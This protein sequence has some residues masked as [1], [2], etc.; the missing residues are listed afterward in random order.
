MKN[1]HISILYLIFIALVLVCVTSCSEETA[2]DYQLHGGQSIDNSINLPDGGTV[3]LSIACRKYDGS[4]GNK[5]L[6]LEKISYSILNSPKFEK[7]QIEYCDGENN[8]R[9]TNK[10]ISKEY[11]IEANKVLFNNNNINATLVVYMTNG[12]KRTV[13]CP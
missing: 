10:Q 4:D 13:V 5:Y 8:H 2:V 6:E 11:V 3:T 1:K 9:V 7:V 12:E